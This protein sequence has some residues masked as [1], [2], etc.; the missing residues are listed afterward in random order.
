MVKQL[1]IAIVSRAA[2]QFKRKSSAPL[3]DMVKTYVTPASRRWDRHAPSAA[4]LS[5][6]VRSLTAN[7][8][9]ELE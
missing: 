2:A 7:K 3:D 1:P 9:L 5:A 4:D 6:S 8:F